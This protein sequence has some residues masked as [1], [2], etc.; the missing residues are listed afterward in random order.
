MSRKRAIE[1]SGRLL[2]KIITLFSLEHQRSH[3]CKSNYS[4]VYFHSTPDLRHLT[5]MLLSQCSLSGIPDCVSVCSSSYLLLSLSLPFCKFASHLIISS[6]DQSKTNCS[7]IW[8]ILCFS[9]KLVNRKCTVYGAFQSN[10]QRQR[11]TEFW[12]KSWRRVLNNF[13]GFIWNS[14]I[15]IL[16]EISQKQIRMRFDT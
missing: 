6:F 10:T 5:S 4:L 7:G 9:V 1:V 3:T 8:P 2:S 11:M 14:D 13:K 16:E 15:L 12:G